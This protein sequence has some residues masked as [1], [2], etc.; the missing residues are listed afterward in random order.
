MSDVRISSAGGRH[1]LRAL[2]RRALPLLVVNLFYFGVLV[3]PVLRI[4]SLLTPVPPGTVALLVIMVGPIIGRLACEWLPGTFTRLLSAL[5]LTW[6]GLCFMAFTLVICWEVFGWLLP[7]EDRT[8]GLIL[9]GAVSLV[10]LYALQN[11][12]TLAV[13]TVPMTGPASMRG[14][15]LVQIS[16]IHVGSRHG[17]F[18]SRVVERVNVLAPDQVLITGDLIDFADIGIDEIAALGRLN[19]PATFIIGNHERYVDLE[20]IC[21][22]L[23]S[24]G[25]RV[26]RNETA[27]VGPMQLIGIDDAEPKTQ[28]AAE[29]T[30]LRPA[31]DSYRILLYHRPDGAQDAADWGA[32][33]MLCGHTHNGQILPFNL[34]VRRIFPRI[35]GRYEV[36]GMTLYVS[37]GTGTWGPVLRLGSRCEISLLTFA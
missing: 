24:L 32:H 14:Q 15:R 8:W 19:A 17:R 23:R 12:Q 28:V 27:I 31:G 36:D 10:G 6:L 35:C 26:L 34:L 13:K 11:A 4:W 29:L 9:L 25:V 37:P 7:L 20:A 5:A 1:W 22:R 18:L 30:R 2:Q 21:Q 16:D 33:L 3:Y